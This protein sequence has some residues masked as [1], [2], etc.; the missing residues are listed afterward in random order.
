[1]DNAMNTTKVT[2]D[3]LVGDIVANIPGAADALMNAG[4]HCL[5]CPASQS[6][7]LENSSMVH[8]L[9]PDSVV[10]AVNAAIAEA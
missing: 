6:E 9:D 1:M 3:M 8:G 10:E 7:S 2:K 5:G 4:M